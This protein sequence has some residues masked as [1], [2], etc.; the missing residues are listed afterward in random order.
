MFANQPFARIALQAFGIFVAFVIT[1]AVIY[2]DILVMGN[3]MVEGSLVEWKQALLIFGSAIFFALGARHHKDQRG[4]LILVT[5]LFLCMFVRENDGVLDGIVHGFW[6]VPVL[7]IAVVGGFFVFKY[8]K[9][10][11]PALGQH[12]QDSSFWIMTVG[13]LQLVVFSRLFG[14]GKLWKNIPNQ[15]DLAVAKSIVQESTELAGYSLIFLGAYLSH[16]YLFG[17]KQS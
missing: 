16:K 8:R 10:I 7:I 14:S 9:N 13:F 12:A 6:R 17:T 2:V 11:R 15:A 5:T 4:Y 1:I 3:A